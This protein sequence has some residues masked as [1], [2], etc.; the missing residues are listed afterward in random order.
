MAHSLLAV[1]QVVWKIDRIVEWTRQARCC[2][3]S[4]VTWAPPGWSDDLS[5]LKYPKRRSRCSSIPALPSRSNVTSPFPLSSPV[6][7][8]IVS[9]DIVWRNKQQ[10]NMCIRLAP[11][12]CS[13][14]VKRMYLLLRSR[15]LWFWKYVY[16]R[17]S[18]IRSTYIVRAL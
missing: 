6:R 11:D 4:Q 18:S 10:L 3:W 13:V 15:F 12:C 2:T 7:R 16:A 1:M 14:P 17:L 8:S 5:A 9:F